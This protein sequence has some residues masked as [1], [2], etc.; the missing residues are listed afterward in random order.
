MLKEPSMGAVDTRQGRFADSADEKSRLR[1]VRWPMSQAFS[2][3][4]DD[5]LVDV[6]YVRPVPLARGARA[7]A[8]RL[9]LGVAFGAIRST[10]WS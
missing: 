5:R 6:C 9:T 4:C 2:E 1:P 10:D 8:T 3:P 7:T